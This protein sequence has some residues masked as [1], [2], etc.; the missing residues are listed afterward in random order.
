MFDRSNERSSFL[1]WFWLMNIIKV[2]NKSNLRRS[3]AGDL[4]EFMKKD[5][6]YYTTSVARVW[7]RGSANYTCFLHKLKLFRADLVRSRFQKDSTGRLTASP[8]QIIFYARASNSMSK[9]SKKVLESDCLGIAIRGKFIFARNIIII[10]IIWNNMN[11]Y[12]KRMNR[13]CY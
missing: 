8:S 1:S 11:Y 12:E 5:E 4:A 6:N 10:I 3:F 7:E 9:S 2:E 13:K